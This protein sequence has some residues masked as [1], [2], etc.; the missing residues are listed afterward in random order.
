MK[1]R[2]LLI[3]ALA[4]SACGGAPKCP[5]KMAGTCSWCA[6]QPKCCRSDECRAC[7]PELDR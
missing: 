3:A 1:R 7:C 2:C 5:V 6:E 4:L